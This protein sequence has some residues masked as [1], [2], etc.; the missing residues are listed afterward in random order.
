[1][2]IIAEGQVKVHDGTHIL[3]RLNAG[4]VFWRIRLIDAE[5]RSASVT[6]AEH[7]ILYRIDQEDFL[8][9]DGTEH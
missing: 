6:A 9:P 7:T 1:M 8:C 4:E 5:K 3:T 2:F